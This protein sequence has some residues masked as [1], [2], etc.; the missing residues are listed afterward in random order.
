[1]FE[2]S[3][4]CIGHRHVTGLHRDKFLE[5]VEIIVLRQ[6]TGS[7]KFLL[8]NRHEV[9]QVL[10]MV[11]AD[12]VDFV[13]RK[14]KSVL[15]ITLLRCM[16]H[17]ADYAFNDVVDVGEIP[18]A[19][20]V[21]EY[22]YRLALTELVCEAEVG[23]VRTTCRSIHCEEPQSSRRDIVELAVGMGHQLVALLC[24]RIKAYRIVYLVVGRV[25]DLFVGAVDA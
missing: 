23:H 16:L 3:G 4:V 9:Q 7:K 20:A 25:W 12:V 15:P 17:D 11:V 19:V 1:M 18:L 24:C 8:K 22:F 10:W 6:N 21:V 13:W 14:R 2:R 5:G